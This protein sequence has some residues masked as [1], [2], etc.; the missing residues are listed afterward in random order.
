MPA[1]LSGASLRPLLLYPH[2]DDA[3][4]RQGQIGAVERIEMEILHAFGGEA[5]AKFSNRRRRHQAARF[6]VVVEPV[7]QF[8]QPARHG[9][10]A[11]GRH[12]HERACSAAVSLR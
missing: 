4:D 2:A 9:R 7:E 12:L 5:R 11:P 6:R 3:A 10:L 8:R 1:V